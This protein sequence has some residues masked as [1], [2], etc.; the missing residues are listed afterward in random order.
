ML[1]YDLFDLD[2]AT[3]TEVAFTLDGVTWHY[4]MAPASDVS[5]TTPDISGFTGGSLTAEGS[6]AGAP[7]SSDGTR[8]AP[9]ASSGVTSLPAWRTA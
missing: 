4:R 1:G 2:G 9:A 7:P 6:S 3:V 5:E 8:A